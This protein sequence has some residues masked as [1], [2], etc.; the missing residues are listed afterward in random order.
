MK[1]AATSPLGVGVTLDAGALIALDRGDARVRALL[2]RAEATGDPVV[3]PATALAQAVRA[4]ARQ[5]RLSGLLQQINTHVVPLDR[6]DAV[7]IGLLL[8][9]SGT[10]D[11]VDAHVVLCAARAGQPIVTSDPDDLRRLDPKA[12]LVPL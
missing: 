3:V 5:A 6:G 12:V 9:A 11:V 7:E 8:A 10:S 1:P 2:V 4:P